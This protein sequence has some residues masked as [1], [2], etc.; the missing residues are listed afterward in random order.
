LTGDADSP[1]MQDMRKGPDEIGLFRRFVVM[2][3][4]VELWGNSF[5]NPIVH[6]T[7]GLAGLLI[8]LAAF[9]VVELAM[10]LWYRAARHRI[11]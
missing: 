9:G 5:G 7:V 6:V 1:T 11:R 3:L 4:G 10:A 2:V 8:F